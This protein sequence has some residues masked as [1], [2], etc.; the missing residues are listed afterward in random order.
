M[1][2]RVKQDLENID[3]IR[4]RI[5]I[6]YRGPRET[7]QSFKCSP[8]MAINISPNV[9]LLQ[10]VGDQRNV[11]H[12]SRDAAEGLRLGFSARRRRQR[13]LAGTEAVRLT[14][15]WL[16]AQRWASSVK[17]IAELLT[18]HRPSI[19]FFPHDDDWNKTHIGVHRLIVEAL[20]SSGFACQVVE[21]EFWGAMDSPNLM[22]ESSA[23]DVADLVAA[24]SLHVGEVARN[25]YH[26]RLPAWMI[27]NVRRGAE[28]VGGQ[29][30][31][32]PRFPF[33]TLYRLR[34]WENGRFRDVFEGG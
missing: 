16:D 17:T 26:L 18:E 30:G 19:I 1:A 4:N 29:G 6:S 5:K 13:R 15:H 2:V 11:G 20:A 24:L 22:V 33:A 3:Y 34:R 23:S 12:R 31:T 32:A 7:H 10:Q 14:L 28:L 27:D 21:T 25:A 8:H 9:A